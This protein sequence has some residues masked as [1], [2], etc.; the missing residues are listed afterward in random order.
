MTVTQK[1]I[2]AARAERRMVWAA[3]A[4]AK[5]AA[6]T[7]SRN[8]DHAFMTQPGHIP[9]RA[10]QMAREDRAFEMAQK[11]AAHRAKAENLAKMAQRNKGDAESARQAVRESRDYQAGDAVV[12]VHYGRATVLKVNA[13]TVRIQTASGFKTTQDKSYVKA[14]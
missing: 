10:A 12:S 4:E 14:I 9:A 3:A 5:A 11:A 2:W 7:V 13:K 1:E 6:L 8:T